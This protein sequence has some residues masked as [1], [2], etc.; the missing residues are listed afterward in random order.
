MLMLRPDVNV[1]MLQLLHTQRT[2]GQHILNRLMQQPV[3]MALSNLARRLRANAARITRMPI[4]NFIRLFLA[5][6]NNLLGIHD[7]NLIAAI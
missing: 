3:G 6:E 1:K 2:A 4:I 5:G 7:N